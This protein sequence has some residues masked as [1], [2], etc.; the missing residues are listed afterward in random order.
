[1]KTVVSEA[2]P[3]L[4]PRDADVV[5]ARIE[6]AGLRFDSEDWGEAGDLYRALID[7]LT[8]E[9]GPY[10]DQV[11]YCQRRLAECVLHM[12][13]RDE[14]VDRLTRLQGQMDARYGGADRRVRELAELIE[15]I[16][17]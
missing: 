14:A 11:M 8:A 13:R 10:D 6:L 2:I 4:G 16:R 15:N 1:M 9:R 7:D 5:D 17:R 12:G 3:V